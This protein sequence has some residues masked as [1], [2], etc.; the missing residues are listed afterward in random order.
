M[1]CDEQEVTEG[2]LLR[3]TLYLPGNSSSK[4]HSIF[5]AAE[6]NVVIKY[7]KK[8]CLQK[9]NVLFLQDVL[10]LLSFICSATEL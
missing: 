8:K 4:P 1:L 6:R 7:K 5:V 3:V 2:A 10:S 9:G